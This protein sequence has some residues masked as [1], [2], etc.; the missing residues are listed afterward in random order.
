MAS[1]QF[2]AACRQVGR[3]F[4][5]GTVAGL[6]EGQLLDR[7]VARRDDAAFEALVAR[8][9]PM[10]LAVCRSLLRDPNDVDD[11][12]QAVFLVLVKRAGSVR[13]R[14]L[15]GPWLHGVARRV[16]LRARTEAARRRDRTTAGV[17]PSRPFDDDL[18]RQDMRASIHAE[19]DRLPASYRAAIVL[20]YFEGRTHEE[21][22]RELGWPVG[23][24][25]GRLARARDLL[26]GRLARRGIG[27][28]PAAL[29]SALAREAEAAVPG[30]LLESTTK[31]AALAAAGPLASL[32]ATSTLVSS[33]ALILAQGVLPVMSASKIKLA[34]TL[35]AVGLLAGP[36]ASA[37]SP[38]DK[39]RSSPKAAREATT[40]VSAPPAA[41]DDPPAVP[42]AERVALAERALRD[43]IRRYTSLEAPLG[44]IERWNRRVLGAKIEAGMD[45]AEAFRA[46]V[47]TSRKVE[48]MAR[49]MVRAGHASPTD[50]VAAQFDRIEAEAHTRQVWNLPPGPITFPLVTGGKPSSRPAAE[51]DPRPILSNAA[52][53]PETPAP[54]EAPP[55]GGPAE[56]LRIAEEAIAAIKAMLKAPDAKANQDVRFTLTNQLERWQGVADEARHALGG[57]SPAYL[58][59]VR[60]LEDRQEAEVQARKQFES[61]SG[62]KIDYLEA[63]LQW[64]QAQ[65]QIEQSA[66]SE[67]RKRPP[68]APTE[69]GAP[70][71]NPGSNPGP[72][73]K[74]KG[75]GDLN[76]G[77]IPDAE[78]PRPRRL[79]KTNPADADRDKAIEGALEQT[80]SL[81]YAAGT[82]LDEI[83]RAIRELTKD[84]KAGLKKGIPIYVDPIVLIEDKPGEERKARSLV[85]LVPVEIDDLPLRV[86]LRLILDQFSLSY[87]VRDR[88]VYVIDE[89]L[90]DFRSEGAI[91]FMKATGSRSPTMG[92]PG[93]GG[94][95]MGGMGTGGPKGNPG[96]FR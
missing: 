74:A 60:F 81:K 77:A 26:R 73:P 33:R 72:G 87:Q 59:A 69:A 52:P 12:F 92:G 75:E 76:V 51:A 64:L 89:E 36:G 78:P 30:V 9:G 39:G 20:C 56:R 41:R 16:A 19:I 24:V 17:E 93:M 40:S 70:K 63:R 80:V 67:A 7:F 23:T 42:A 31:A 47:E 85:T 14:D 95:G 8:H 83:L 88:M 90:L 66:Q 37:D 5:A 58:N 34:A 57:P 86:A 1:G 2:T 15:L 35:I 82:P 13:H 62:T 45:Q 28:A 44:N 25:R 46:Y 6:G 84:E 91:D 71:T 43:E 18:D 32:L 53:K 54:A 21:A 79:P 96:G 10:V 65:Q 48:Q 49:D 11:A 55:G 29:L 68:A 38:T 94:M 50:M 27:L 61:G 22:A 3:L 4:G